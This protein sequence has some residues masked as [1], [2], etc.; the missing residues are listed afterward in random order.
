MWIGHRKEIWISLWWL[1]HIINH[2][3]KT[4]LHMYCYTCTMWSGRAPWNG[5][6]GQRLLLEKAFIIQQAKWLIIRQRHT[7][8]NKGENLN[9][10]S[11]QAF[12]LVPRMS[13][14]HSAIQLALRWN[15]VVSFTT[16]YALPRQ[17]K[18]RILELSI[19]RRQ[20]NSSFVLTF[21]SC[22]EIDCYRGVVSAGQ[23]G[24]TAA[25]ANHIFAVF[26][27]CWSGRY[28][29]TL[30][31]WPLGKQWVFFPSTSMFPSASPWG[32]LR[33]SG[34]NTH[35]FPWGQSLGASA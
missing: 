24:A 16:K 7:H 6:I 15:I 5:G 21:V 8:I 18:S 19:R 11:L 2:A 31:D 22:E 10:R 26:F 29:K 32:T 35:C 20:S 9:N 13:C 4:K 23:L 14:P 3:D 33:V 27:Y 28:N 25:R 17:I 34:N 1:I 12:N 30:N